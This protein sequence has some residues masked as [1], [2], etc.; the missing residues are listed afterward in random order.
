VQVDTERG[1]VE[2]REALPD[3]RDDDARQHV[4]A[5]G[6]AQGR[7]FEG[8]QDGAAVGAGDIVGA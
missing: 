7:H 1:S 6:R 8:G 5:A 2:G 3:E 4:A